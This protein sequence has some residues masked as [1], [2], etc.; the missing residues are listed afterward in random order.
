MK[1]LYKKQ[2]MKKVIFAIVSTMLLTSCVEDVTKKL[3]SIFGAATADT[4]AVV[5][6]VDGNDTKQQAEKEDIKDLPLLVA[7]GYDEPDY[8]APVGFT[9]SN[10]LSGDEYGALS[11][12]QQEAENKLKQMLGEHEIGTAGNRIVTWKSIS[13]ERLDSKTLKAEHPTLYQKYTNKTSYRRFSV[14][15]AV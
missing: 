9:P 12:E 13:Q 8:Y 10:Q 2:N 6:M 3:K 11:E 5:N 4:A 14:R 15:E 1:T 7:A